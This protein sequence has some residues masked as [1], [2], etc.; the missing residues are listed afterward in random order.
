MFSVKF[1]SCNVV[2]LLLITVF[3]THPDRLRAHIKIVIIIKIKVKFRD[4]I[5][6]L[7]NERFLPFLLI[8]SKAFVGF[9]IKSFSMLNPLNKVNHPYDDFFLSGKSSLQSFR[10]E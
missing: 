6:L 1:K 4:T 2:L 8:S 7:K 10:R 5:F 9:L 3:S